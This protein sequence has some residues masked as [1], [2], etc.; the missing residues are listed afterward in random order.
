M[1]LRYLE[2]RM[3]KILIGISVSLVTVPLLII[4]GTVLLKGGKVL[5]D[6]P[7]VLITPPGSR[8]LITGEGGFLHAVL[9]SLYLVIPATLIA[10]LMGFGIALF[11]QSDYTSQRIS[12]SIRTCLDV[13]WGTPSIVYGVFVLTILIFINQRG[14][15]LAGISALTLLELPIITRYADEAIRAVPKELKDACYSI[16]TTRYE[17]SKVVGRY[18]LPGIIAGVLIGMGRGI[19]DAASVI[20]TSGVSSVMPGGLFDSVTAM[21]ILIFQQASSC[22]PT[23]RGHAYA[24][25]FTLILIVGILNFLSRFLVRKLSKYVPGG[26]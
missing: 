18:A 9:G 21:P 4:I 14:C 3:F 10:S 11:L 8:Y 12:G 26:K 17:A 2:E 6:N 20:F 13:L 22:Y 7:G 16:G 15:L 23:V 5:V 1:K 25:A 19:G 24:A